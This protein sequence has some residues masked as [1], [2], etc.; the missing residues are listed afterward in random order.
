MTVYASAFAIRTSEAI[1]ING[2]KTGDQ[3]KWADPD[4]QCKWG[5]CQGVIMKGTEDYN[6]GQH[7]V[8]WFKGCTR[9]FDHKG[10]E[11]DDITRTHVKIAFAI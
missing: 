4:N 11:S 6:L 9:H 8:F 5:I 10:H 2:Y 1:S 7:V 3:V